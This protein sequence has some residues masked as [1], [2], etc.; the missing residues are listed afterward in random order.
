MARKHARILVS[1]WDDEDF[2]ALT[3]V[4]QVVYFAVL[5]SKDLSW[6]GVNPLLPQRFAGIA[7]D[8]TERR[9]LAAFDVLAERRFLIADHDTAEVA[10][11]TFVRHDDILQQPNVTK[12]MG[13]A[14]GLVRS[15]TIREAIIAELT[16]AH[17][18]LP[19]A[20]GWG[21]LRLAYP[22]LFAE[23]IGKG[24]GNPSPNPSRKAS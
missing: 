14:I 24:S 7:C 18:E 11:R 1:I 10:A 16:R 22:E 4:Q 20:K 12:A 8:I 3:A 17:R 5:S 2:V 23:V 21:S 13:R 15:H 9:A 19:D 6:C